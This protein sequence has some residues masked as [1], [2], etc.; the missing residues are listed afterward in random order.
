MEYME[1]ALAL[2]RLALG[3]VSPNPAVG[4]VLVN[5]GVVVGQGY[6]QPPGGRHAEIVALEQAGEAA[7][8]STLYVTLEPC[9]H[10]GRTPPCSQALIKAGIS[11]AHIAMLDPNPLVAGKGKAELESAGIETTLGQNQEQAR[12]L[13]EA[14]LKY[15]TTGMP[16]I[17]VKFAMS[18]DGKIATRTGDSRWISSEESRQYAHNLRYIN[19]AIMCGVNTVL[20]DDPQLTTRCCGGRGGTTKKQPLRIV[21]D[22]RGRTPSS[23]RIFHEQGETLLVFGRAPSARERESFASLRADVV[24]FPAEDGVIKLKEL[25]R[26]LGQRQVASVLVEGGG[27]LIGSLFDQG[28]VDKVVAFVAPIIIGGPAMSPVAGGGV[29]K[30]AEAYSLEHVSSSRSGPDIVIQGYVNPVK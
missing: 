26:W 2:A 23:A 14:Y 15:V 11:R 30:L 8:G 29:E 5:N 3:Q 9:S 1:Q 16:F 20:A 19:D 27:V 13:N 10:F 24:E 25:F 28:Q 22:G 4:A 6:T 7:R 21:I 18:L 12:E 17:T